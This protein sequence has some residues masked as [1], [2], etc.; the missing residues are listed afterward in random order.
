MNVEQVDPFDVSVSEFN[1]RHENINTSELEPSVEELGI[2]QPPVVRKRDVEDTKAG[3]LEVPYEVVI[4]QRRVGAAQAVGLDTIPVVVMDWDDGQSLA[5][6]IAENVDTF[7]EDVSKK[8]RALAIERLKELNNWNGNR[9]VADELGVPSS[10]IRSWLE[11]VRDEWKGTPVHSE[12]V[13]ESEDPVASY[14]LDQNVDEKPTET[15]RNVRAVTG[16]GDKGVEALKTIEKEGLSKD[17]VV[18]A[19]QRIDEDESKSFTESVKE[20]GDEKSKHE[21][22][23][24]DRRVYIDFTLSSDEADAIKAAAEDHSSTPKQIALAAIRQYLTDEG[25][26]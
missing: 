20:V 2:V 15:V 8:D 19:K 3:D 11:Y 24:R 14:G 18:E 17:D 1:E 26:L 16:G 25:H 7:R 13:S 21:G 9:E 10:T 5:A 12:Y 6:S 23:D 4:G 22:V